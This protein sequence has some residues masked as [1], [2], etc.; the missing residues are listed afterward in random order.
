MTARILTAAAAVLLAGGA[1]PAGAANPQ[2]LNLVMPDAQV[3]AGV[4]VDQARSSAFGQYV[5]SQ[6]KQP[7]LAGLTAQTGFDPT[8]DVHEVL[9]A[10]GGAVTCASLTPCKHFGLLLASGT[11]NAAAIATAASAKPGVAI[12]PY[13][14]TTIIESPD[15]TH[16]VAFLSNG[17][18]AVAGDVASVKAAIDRQ[19]ATSP[20][21]PA[22]VVMQVGQWSGSSDAWVI[23]TVPPTSLHPPA[24]VPAM[25]G[26]GQGGANNAF[27]SILSAAA[28]V[29]FAAKAAVTIEA[30]A[31][32][33]QDATTVGNAVQLL[34]SMALLQ[35]QT[36][37]ALQALA[38]SLKVTT[39]GSTLNISFSLPESDL[40]ALLKRHQ[41][42][43]RHPAPRTRKQD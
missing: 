5:L 34:A 14:N 3:L 36:D 29:K 17:T 39:A 35:H 10:S 2:L 13:G 7:A 42:M 16:G 12:E 20:G 41:A 25:P 4:N 9:A 18:I 38:Q 43:Q 32:N 31:D 24:G 33:A 28:G 8:Q 6:V 30:L 26:V 1:F 21:L 27:Q 19:S 23:S 22:A 15:K 37:P 40:Q 11:F